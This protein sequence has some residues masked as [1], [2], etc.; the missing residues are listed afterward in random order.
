[1]SLL[2]PKQCTLGYILAKRAHKLASYSHTL[3][4]LPS[5]LHDLSWNVPA[6]AIT[7]AELAMV[8]ETPGKEPTSSV[9]GCCKTLVLAA[10]SD[11]CEFN[12]FHA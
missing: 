10:H 6:C 3:H 5:D 8:V 7:V 12:A 2:F 4:L 9:D 11:V 1:M